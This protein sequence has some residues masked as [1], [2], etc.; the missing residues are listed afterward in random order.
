MLFT[1]LQVSVQTASRTVADGSLLVD[2][3]L[4]AMCLLLIATFG[5]VWRLNERMGRVFG[6]V[7]DKPY[8]VVAMMEKMETR[9]TALDARVRTLE[10][11]E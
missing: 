7:F 1:L 10:D 5:L 6:A 2:A 3:A 4:G 8:G 9:W 11:A